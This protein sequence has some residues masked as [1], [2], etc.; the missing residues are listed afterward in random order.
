MKSRQF[1]RFAERGGQP[2]YHVAKVRYGDQD[3][4]SLH[5]GNAATLWRINLGWTRRKDRDQHGFVLDIERGYWQRHQADLDDDGDPMTPKTARVIPYVEDRKNCLIIEFT[6]KLDDGEMA[7]IQ[8]AIKN[9]IQACYELENSE[10][11]AEPLPD[12]GDRRSILLY[13]SAEGGAG[14]LR[15]IVDNAG[16]LPRIARTALELCHFDPDSGEDLRRAPNA[17]ENCEAACYDCLMSYTN[18]TDHELLDR[19]RIKDLLMML[20]ASHVEAS[21]ASQPRAAHLQGLI[22]LTGSQLERDWL[23]MIEDRNLRLPSHA[24]ALVE[25]CRTRPDF[26]Y[27]DRQVAIY[28]DGPQHELSM[29]DSRVI[30]SRPPAWKM[31]AGLSFASATRITGKRFWIDIRTFLEKGHDVCRRL[32]RHS[33]RARMG[34]IAGIH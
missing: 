28:V 6:R 10:L 1:V 24:Q 15:R 30:S 16:A 13:E 8:A 11:A 4:V 3:V 26:C 27:R 18:Q 7:T 12:R 33:P 29:T 21:P 34:C 20:A 2:S 25:E 9:A 22:N 17:K 32:P 19:Q 14:V 31:Q 23:K 5:F